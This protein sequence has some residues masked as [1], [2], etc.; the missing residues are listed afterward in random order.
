[1]PPEGLVPESELIL[2]LTQLLELARRHVNGLPDGR[3]VDVLALALGYY[4]EEPQDVLYDAL[5]GA[6]L[7]GFGELGIPVFVAAGNESTI[8]PMYPA[9]F[10]PQSLVQSRS[11]PLAPLTS[12]GA[13]NP[14][15]S[16]ALFS[17]T[18]DWVLAWEK[19]AHLVSTFPQTFSG[20]L[21]PEATLADPSNQI[22][23]AM[24]PD[25]YLG[26]FGL[27]SGTSFASPLLAG[28]VAAAMVEASECG[29]AS[30]D[31]TGPAATLARATAAMDAVRAQGPL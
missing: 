21:N 30:L 7:K 1:V 19:G 29:S 10:A 26:G 2:T 17:N 18:G 28:R 23:R 8:R 6:P 12:V 5:I 15:G 25:C 27:W 4:H 3:P 31:D 11:R 9:A 22:R 24:D 13:L 14:D 16:V 20:G